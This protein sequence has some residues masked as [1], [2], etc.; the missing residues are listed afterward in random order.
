MY[1]SKNLLALSII[2]VIYI[3]LE[4]LELL[5]GW[6]SRSMSHFILIKLLLMVV[7]NILRSSMQYFRSL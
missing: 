5:L 2:T 7:N 4:A 6:M 3:S 1:S